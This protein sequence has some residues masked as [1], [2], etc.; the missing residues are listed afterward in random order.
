MEKHMKVLAAIAAVLCVAAMAGGAE[1]VEVLVADFEGKDYGEWK[2]EGEAFGPGPARG[3]LANQMEVSGFVGKGLV[4]SFY[5][6]DGTTGRLTSPAF[7]IERKYVN[8]L[9][10]AGM[11]PGKT[12]INLLLDGKVVRTATG[13]NDRPGGTERLDWHT[14]DV[15]EL[16]GKTVV[17]EIV[18]METGGWGHIN[19]DQ[20]VQSDVKKGIMVVDQKRE[21]RIEDRYL[22]L[23]VKHGATKRRMS[24][25]VD[26]KTQREF[27]IELAEGEADFWVFL[28]VSQW[29]GKE[30][31]VKVDR[32]PA[33]SRALAAVVQGDSIEGAENLYKE[34]LRPQFHFTSRRGWNNDPN[35]LVYHKGEYH[36]FYQHNPYGWDWGNMHWGHA[37]SRDL[38]R[39]KEL[40][41]AIYPHEFGDWVFSGSAVVDQENTA[42]FK[43]GDEDVIVAAYTSTG[44][45]EAIAHSNDRGR[46]FAE[47]EG[48]PVVKHSGRDPKLIWYEPGKHWVMAVYDE[49]AGKRGIAFHTSSDLKNWERRSFIEGYFECPEIFE[50]AVDG[51]KNNRKWVV[52]GGDGNYAIGSFDGKT[53]TAESGKHQA[54]YGNCFYASQTF[55]NIAAED[56]RR[57]RIGWGTVAT[58]GMPFNQMM[59]FPVELTLR[60]TEAGVRMFA[61]PVKEIEGIRWKKHEVKGRA[62]RPGENALAGVSGELC[63][64]ACEIEVGQASEVGFN[65][66]GVSVVYDAKGQKLICRDKS[67]PMKAVDG[68]IRLRMLVDRT[69]IEIFGNDGLV[70]MPMG[71]IPKDEERGL[72]VFGKGGEGRII[73][74]E[75]FELRSAWE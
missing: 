52:Y 12:C 3:T 19:I 43:K 25:I 68:K 45:G 1:R 64:I 34:K 29:K 65:I 32:L 36:L 56:G 53:F 47:Y 21:I 33:D 8:F 66:R 14:W 58:P 2:V 55:N 22:S 44:R 71:V 54:S 46:T 41:I 16:A 57:I 31:T 42:G 72:E 50:L 70:Y 61:M 51:D 74:L 7:K 11:H 59:N 10:G 28:D 39:W 23:P 37:V 20:I 67:A 4:D 38:V 9:I 18:D 27:E 48:N 75:V 15:A 62:L 17:I 69:S 30:G 5:G 13:P 35:G 63:D 26:G 73:S 6:G 24:F 60:T 40:P 49:P